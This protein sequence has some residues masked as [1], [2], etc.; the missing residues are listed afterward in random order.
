MSDAEQ[1]SL[2]HAER[3]DGTTAL[4]EVEYVQENIERICKATILFGTR[5]ALQ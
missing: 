4:R 5:E 1:I 3:G 2:R